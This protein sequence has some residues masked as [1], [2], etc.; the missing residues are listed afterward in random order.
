MYKNLEQVR[1]RKQAAFKA[2]QVRIKELNATVD[3][4]KKQNKVLRRYPEELAYKSGLAENR[5]FRYKQAL[6][7][8]YQY[9]YNEYMAHFI[10]GQEA[11]YLDINIIFKIFK[12]AGYKIYN[13]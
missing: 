10:V 2:L 13:L 5:A 8:I 9:V 7:E 1:K 3:A 6:D 4:L 11:K 12:K